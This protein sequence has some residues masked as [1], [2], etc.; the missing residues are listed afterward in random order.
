VPRTPSRA[1]SGWLSVQEI[2]ARKRLIEAVMKGD[3]GGGA[4]RPSFPGDKKLNLLKPGADTLL[5]VFQL[6]ASSEYEVIDL[7]GGAIASTASAHPIQTMSGSTVA[8]GSARARRWR[9]S[10]AGGGRA[11]RAPAASAMR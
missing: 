3:D 1:I 4:L 8:I 2:L 10:T 7:P 5:S 9:R 11:R 6:V